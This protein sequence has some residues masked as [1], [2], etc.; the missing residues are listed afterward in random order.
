M[1]F[2]VFALVIGFIG[3]KYMTSPLLRLVTA[4]KQIAAGD[5]SARVET[6]NITEIGTLGRDV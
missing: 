3:A 5:F 1:A 2:A 6:N 4:A